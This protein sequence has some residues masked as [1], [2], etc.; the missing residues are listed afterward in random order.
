MKCLADG[1]PYCAV[2][3]KYTLS[4]GNATCAKCLTKIR[5]GT[6]AVKRSDEQVE[7]QTCP[8]KRK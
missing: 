4:G 2:H 6:F 7:H 8:E 5:A 3:K 1:E